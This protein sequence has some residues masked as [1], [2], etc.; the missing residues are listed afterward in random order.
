MC[1]CIEQINAKLPNGITVETHLLF[2]GSVVT[3]KMSVRLVD[4]NGKPPRKSAT[5]VF[6]KY[7]PFCG[8]PYEEPLQSQ[9]I[10]VHCPQCGRELAGQSVGPGAKFGHKC[11]VR[12]ARD[13]AG[14]G[15]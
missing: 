7:C 3:E 9:L 5:R 11:H 12:L 4:K 14:T 6:F 2:V 10:C 13:F 1:D 15:S 8:K